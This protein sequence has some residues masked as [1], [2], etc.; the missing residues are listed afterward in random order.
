MY[1]VS[2]TLI[3]TKKGVRQEHIGRNNTK[4]PF[5]SFTD[6]H[7]RFERVIS[8]QRVVSLP[9]RVCVCAYAR[10]LLLLMM[11]RIQFNVDFETSKQSSEKLN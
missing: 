11:Y 3:C 5:L 7:V 1:S 2:C 9:T 8:L 10:V 6:C 4:Q